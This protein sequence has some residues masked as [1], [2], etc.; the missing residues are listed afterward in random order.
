M[1]HLFCLPIVPVHDVQR[2][3]YVAKE[4]ELTTP[5]ISQDSV[6]MAVVTRHRDLLHH[7]S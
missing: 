3:V 1:S 4:F 5:S 6:R 2:P 7:N